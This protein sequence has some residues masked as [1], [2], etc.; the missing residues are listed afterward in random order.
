MKA[1]DAFSYRDLSGKRRARLFVV[2]SGFLVGALLL[3]TALFLIKNWLERA[4]S[5]LPVEGTVSLPTLP[6]QAALPTATPVSGCPTEPEQWVFS[7]IS[8]GG[9][10]KRVSP[11]CAL[12]GLERVV[13]WRLASDLGYN[14]ASA[15]ALL[16]FEAQ[17]ALEIN[18]VTAM[19]QNDG[20]LKMPLY[21]SVDNYPPEYQQ[22][23]VDDLGDPGV[24]YSLR[25]C[26]RTYSVDAITLEKTDWGAPFQVM[27]MLA[28]DQMGSWIITQYD[29]LTAASDLH[30]ALRLFELY[31][32]TDAGQWVFIGARRKPVVLIQAEGQG[33]ILSLETARNDQE[34]M[35]KYLGVPVWDATWLESAY[36][37]QAAR[38]PADWNQAADP[39]L[40]RAIQQRLETWRN[41]Q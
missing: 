22:W 18:E 7:D 6:A 24:V 31:G 35:A 5:T 14:P 40:H 34:N 37:L 3:L 17:P 8:L 12:D 10:L 36:A 4:D 16:G 9:N 13:A 41:E 25:G 19:T 27:C 28:R 2:A 29:G 38:L 26:Y 30:G 20:P 11:E 15:A 32:Y 33:D 23:L 39:G 1:W 21:S